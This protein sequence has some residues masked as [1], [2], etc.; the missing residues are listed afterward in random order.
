[1]KHVP[2][3][4]ALV[5]AGSSTANAEPLRLRGDALATTASPAGLL[6]LEA[7]GSQS[8]ELSA[9][10]VVWMAGQPAPGEDTRGDVLVIAL[11]ARDP[12]G[13]ASATLGRF[14]ASVG[15]LRPVHI[16]G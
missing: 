8:R 11:R 16:D 4:A 9:E 13:R 7:T 2:L 10:A 1:M 15:A 6:T 14:V 12:K 3:L 5:A